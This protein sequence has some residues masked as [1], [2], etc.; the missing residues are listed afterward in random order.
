M[1]RKLASAALL[2][3]LL[4]MGAAAQDART[5]I[6][7]AS[8]A[9]G[10]DTLS[11]V[12]YSGSASNGNFGQSKNIAGPLAPTTITN[13]TRAIDLTVPAS[14]ATGAT[15]PPAV[16][17]GPPP[18]PGTFTQN[19]APANA[20]W[21]QQLE[22]WITP[23]G[24]LKGAAAN[25][26][27]ARAQRIGGRQYNVLSWM[28]AQKSPSGQ[29]YR[30]NGYINDQNM[31]ERVETWVEHPVMGDLH[32]DT[33]YSNYQDFGGLKI[34]GKIVQ[35]RAGLQTFDATITSGSAN[36]NNIAQ[37]LTQ[38]QPQGRGGA[39][40]AAPGGAPAGPPPAPAVQSEK[41]ADGVYRITGGYVALAVEM[42][43]HIVVLESGQSEARG[44]AILAEARRVIPNKPIRY[45]V[46]THAHFDHASGL[47]PVVAEGI[48]IITH[49]NNKAFLEK[50]LGG[51]RTLVGDTLAKAN[52]KPRIESAGDRK[53]LRDDTRTIELH[54]V[55]NLEHS[56]GML[57][58][59]L[60]REKILF[61][62][63]FN[64]PAAGQPVLPAI[65][66]LVQNVERLKLDFDTHVLVH[67][68]V[69]DRP[70]TKADLLALAKGATNGGS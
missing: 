17:G 5:I 65:P 10:A 28:P 3:T 67:A 34:P 43:D 45:V 23:W 51:P 49:D 19:I 15:M 64:V 42:K 40:A 54:H 61:T 69:P 66:T 44:L 52:R 55:K 22:I 33:S 58:A 59:F 16:P 37:L 1:L 48:T 53:V 4:S 13:Y 6:A 60:P 25:N 41:L 8:R 18:Q 47:A 24:F 31:V 27:T 63:D 26:A 68:P 9:M 20:A 56:D 11:S 50:A 21:T 2:M 62:G 14:R 7:N 70:Q 32:V 12:V 35:K 38:P 46:N 29:P 36:P 39:P 30:L 57:I